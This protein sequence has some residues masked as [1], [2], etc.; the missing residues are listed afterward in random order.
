[1]PERHVGE[2]RETVEVGGA[3]K[4]AHRSEQ[5][6]R[7]RQVAALHLT[8]LP[9]REIGRRLGVSDTTVCRDLAAIRAEWIRE[10]RDNVA[11]ATLRELASLDA[12]EARWRGKMAAAKDEETQFKCY[13]LVLKIMERR[14]RL[15]GLDAPVR[16]QVSGPGGG[17]LEVSVT[18]DHLVRLFLDDPRAADLGIELLERLDRA[19][20]LLAEPPDAREGAPGSAGEARDAGPRA[21]APA[22][23]AP[24]P[25]AP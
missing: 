21:S 9:Q 7:R 16:A 11:T 4:A 8:R 12:D 22:P 6:E 1:M 17:P 20:S 19:A 15:L 23:L 3:R 14:A 13:T 18:H 2:T 10:A 5:A 24:R 25:E